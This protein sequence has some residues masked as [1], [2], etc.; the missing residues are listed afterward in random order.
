MS[1]EIEPYYPSLKYTQTPGDDDTISAVK[2]Q[3]HHRLSSNINNT[4]LNCLQSTSSL[5]D[6]GVRLKRPDMVTRR[7][8]P[9]GNKYS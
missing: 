5:V 9:A 6:Q 4:K 2:Q 8:I 1:G 3:Q 7:C